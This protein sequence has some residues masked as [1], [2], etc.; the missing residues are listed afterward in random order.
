G[1]D[2]YNATWQ[3]RAAVAEGKSKPGDPL[4]DHPRTE[5]GWKALE[6]SAGNLDKAMSGIQDI[7]RYGQGEEGK[8]GAY[9]RDWLPHVNGSAKEPATASNAPAQGT[10]VGVT[11]ISSQAAYS[12]GKLDE[13]KGFVVHH[14]GGRQPPEGVVGTLNQRG[15]GV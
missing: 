8:R 4:Y 9:A 6:G 2:P 5:R 10:P 12:N 1:G 3:A 11:D 13:V 7:E 14:T 15:L